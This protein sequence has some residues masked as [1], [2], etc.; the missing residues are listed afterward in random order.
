[1][2]DEDK[3]IE[4]LTKE[5]FSKADLEKFL[6]AIRENPELNDIAK[7]SIAINKLAEED[8]ID[9]DILA[10]YILFL[11]GDKL[12]ESD[13]ILLKPKIEMHL[14][15]CVKCRNDFEILSSELS[16]IDNYLSEQIISSQATE[17]IPFFRKVVN[18]IFT[19][20]QFKYGFAAAASV[21]ILFLS[22]FG[23]SELTT[24]AYIKITSQITLEDFSSTR[25][26]TSS[27]FTNALF[28]LE[29]KNYDSAFDELQKDIEVNEKDLTIFYSYYLLGMAHL[30]N[31]HSDFLGLFDSYDS[32]E[33][34]SAIYNF[35]KVLELNDSG[36]FQ[37]VNIN[38][39]YF[40]GKSYLLNEDFD[41]AEKNLEIAVKNKSEYTEEAVK[42]LSAIKKNKLL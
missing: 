11:N 25:S 31:A 24:P 27:H 20:H 9:T 2:N 23:I 14:N 32:D 26:R 10:N 3:I 38:T 19:N 37:N 16:E 21:I 12:V 13:L 6:E 17:K 5:N 29:N 18:G 40:L 1:M 22:L 15:N 30:S 4:I 35:N 34:S 42:L 39:Y 33:L 36:L 41:K 28:A 8:H 7:I